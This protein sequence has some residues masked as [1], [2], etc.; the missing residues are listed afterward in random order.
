MHKLTFLLITLLLTVAYGH[1]VAD[2]FGVLQTSGSACCK[3]ACCSSPSN[4]VKENCGDDTHLRGD[5]GNTEKNNDNDFPL[6]SP[7]EFPCQLCLILS[8]DSI[9]TSDTIKVPTPTLVEID[10]DFF[11]SSL[12][13]QLSKIL[14]TGSSDPS[15]K[16]WNESSFEH[17]SPLWRILVKTMPVRGPSFV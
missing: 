1:C 17:N 11:R 4:E 13:E 9:Q 15:L 12:I 2:Q 7:E 3:V 10:P 5:H 6:N 14:S 16:Y 8:N